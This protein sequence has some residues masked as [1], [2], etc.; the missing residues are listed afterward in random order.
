MPETDDGAARPPATRHPGLVS[1]LVGVLLTPRRTFGDVVRQPKWLGALTVVTLTMAGATGWLVSTEVG[2]QA[3]LEQQVGA[4]ESFGGSV[5]DEFYDQLAGNLENATYLTS[6]SVVV[7]VPIVTLIIAGVVW[8]VCYVLWGAHVPFRS[9]YAVV[10][11]VGAVNIVQQLFVVPLNYTRGVMSNPTTV[12]AFFPMLEPGSFLARL[13]GTIDLFI[14]WQLMVLAIG[15]GVL[16]R[17]RTGPIV[18]TLYTLYALIAV[19]IAFVMARIG[20]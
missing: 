7:F 11:H 9:M 2:Q 8:T 20:G 16:F 10:A 5:T 18:T 15:I 14:V 1:R 13:L 3:L 4:I 17:R 12:T 6:G 19:G